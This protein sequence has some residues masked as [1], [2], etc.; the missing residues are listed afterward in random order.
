MSVELEAEV[1]LI[2]APMSAK[3]VQTIL[4]FH[5]L[6]CGGLAEEQRAAGVSHFEAMPP[7]AQTYWIGHQV[8]KCPMDLWVYQEIIWECKPDVIIETGTSGG[9]SAFFFA[10]L[11]D[12]IGKGV[13]ITVDT[14]S[15]PVLQVQHPRIRYLV[16][17]SINPDI[18]NQ[19]ARQAVGHQVMVSLDSLHT[20]AHVTAELEAY[21]PLV[22]P[23]Q[24]LVVEDTGLGSFGEKCD[25]EDPAED[26]AW[27]NLAVSRFLRAHSD[28][29][30]VDWTREKHLLTS[31]HGGWL[32]RIK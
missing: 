31:N 4:D 16:G 9:G 5:A 22:S 8:V 19:I 3:S 2:D 13:V 21:A 6:Y 17:D 28:D 10:T 7:W 25:A 29:F 20:Y 26:G 1:R 14:H 30:E 24:Y 11:L 15:Y 23:G 32:K 27:A 18:V 12:F